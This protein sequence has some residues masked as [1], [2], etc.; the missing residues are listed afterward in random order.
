[1]Y[2]LYMYFYICIYMYWYVVAVKLKKS[3]LKLIKCIGEQIRKRYTI[4]IP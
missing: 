4:F 2:L 1:M 3:E